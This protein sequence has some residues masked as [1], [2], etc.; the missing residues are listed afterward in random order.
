MGEPRPHQ[1]RNALAATAAAGVMLAALA[2]CSSQSPTTRDK[3]PVA[4]ATEDPARGSPMG[5]MVLASGATA[6]PDAAMREGPEH[7][8]GKSLGNAETFKTSENSKPLYLA[9]PQRYLGF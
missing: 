1:I 8:A 6:A 5:M 9:L 2:G 3:G 4:G 7:N